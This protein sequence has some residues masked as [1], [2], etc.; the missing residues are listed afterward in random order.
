VSNIHLRQEIS[1]ESTSKVIESK[2][3]C[4]D[5]LE[6]IIGAYYLEHGV[7]K[8]EEFI[9]RSGIIEH[10]EASLRTAKCIEDMREY[11][12]IL[13]EDQ[14]TLI[15]EAIKYT[16]KRKGL[17]EK[18]VIHPSSHN[19]ILGSVHF[20]RLE[21]VGDCIL[22]VLVTENVFK[23]YINMGP[24][25]MHTMRKSLVNNYTYA[26]ALFKMN[27]SDHIHTCFTKEYMRSIEPRLDVDGDKVSKVFGDI[28]EAICGS[29][30][31]DCDLELGAFMGFFY[32]SIYGV[33]LE[34]AD[35]SR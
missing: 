12:G 25:E 26:R 24:G 15:E 16:F 4:A 35:T 19:N 27:L 14:I 22:D 29:V 5:V 34:C 10:K 7:D 3:T 11:K 6:A 1:S 32:G 31:V 13:P 20:N 28:F 2:K 8:A 23:T 17:L 33:L 9:R 18:A 30:A 21:L